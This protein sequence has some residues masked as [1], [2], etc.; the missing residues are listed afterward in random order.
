MN[1]TIGNNINSINPDFIVD[2]KQD[3]I[4]L[5]QDKITETDEQ[6]L[7]EDYE[8]KKAD[9]FVNIY[10]QRNIK[11][12]QKQLQAKALQET[13][14]FD[15]IFDTMANLEWLRAAYI[16]IAKNKG[17][18]TPGVDGQSIK[19]FEKNLDG[20]LETLAMIIDEGLFEPHPV[21]Y[22]KIPKPN[23][24]TRTISI[25]TIRDRIVQEALRMLIEPIFE[26]GFSPYSFAFRTGTST[27]DAILHLR[28]AGQKRPWVLESDIEAFFDN[29]NHAI[30]LGMVRRKIKDESVLAIIEKFLL[31]GAIDDGQLITTN[32][33]IAQG[34]ILSPLLANIYLSGFDNFI[35]K[36]Y[37][38]GGEP[39][40]TVAYARYADDFI[41]LCNSKAQAVA[42][43][44]AIRG[45]LGSLELDIS[46]EKTAITRLSKGINFLGYQL[47]AVGLLNKTQ[48]SIIIPKATILSLKDKLTKLTI[49]K[50]AE[51]DFSPTDR[52]KI[53]EINRVVSSW[54]HM[55]KAADNAERVFRKLDKFVL[56]AAIVWLAKK[57]N[58]RIARA[59]R[60][61]K[62]NGNIV[63][64]DKK[65][66]LPSHVLK[67]KAN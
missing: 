4:F 23:G 63:I 20:N 57:H 56:S 53:V 27:K 54:S 49:V 16:N 46:A 10:K 26:P 37:V 34:S 28:Q 8:S 11:N 58:L 64:E 29:V 48:V 22:I 39:K 25:I 7:D 41:L 47:K 55:Y 15:N 45:F 42:L 17:S 59:K 2:S 38:E 24:K 52:A 60:K 21:R 31:S 43:S 50:S 13:G 67:A 40:K 44:E 36:G 9:D 12:I 30:L 51:A 3:K 66:I 32:Q 6:L 35:V 14:Y 18:M 1:S 33:G 62:H 19:D 61:F 65:L 5:E